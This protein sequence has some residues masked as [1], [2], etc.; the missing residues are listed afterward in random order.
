MLICAA[1]VAALVMLVVASAVAWE[2]MSATG[3]MPSLL[4]K[5]ATHREEPPSR[6]TAADVLAGKRS[7]A[8]T[9]IVSVKINDGVVMSADSAGN[10]EQRAGLRAREQDH[11]P[12]R[13]LARRCDVT[14]WVASATESVETLL[15]DL[16]RRFNGLDPA[17]AEW[18][19]DPER[20]TLG[21]VAERLRSFL[22]EEK[23]TACRD[24]TNIQLRICGYSAAGR[25]RRSGR[26]T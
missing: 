25:S 5:P 7:A 12:V 2:T 18:R 14:G 21:R 9:I 13:W 11:R 8:V 17:Y 15:K 23:A 24:S 4:E 26:S 19:L 3:W 22:F 6:E 10:H 1:L 16:R 20:Y